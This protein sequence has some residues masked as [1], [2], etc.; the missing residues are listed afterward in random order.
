MIFSF[1]NLKGNSFCVFVVTG[2]HSKKWNKYQMSSLLVDTK[3]SLNAASK[4]CFFFVLPVNLKD[5]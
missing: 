2:P 5:M 3:E 1:A 4:G